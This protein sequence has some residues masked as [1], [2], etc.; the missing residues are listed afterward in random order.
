[1]T[2][3]LEQQ[4]YKCLIQKD[5]YQASSLYEQAIAEAPSKKS[6]YWYLGLAL[7]LQGQ[8]TE[9]QSTWLLA[10][11]EGEVEEVEEWNGELM[12]VLKA[13]AERCDDAT[14]W[15]IRQQMREIQP[16][17]LDNLLHLT[18]LSIKQET[19]TGE[20]LTDWGL[21][22]IVRTEPC[23]TVNPKWLLDI[24]KEVLNSAP[25][26]PATVDFTAA[27][28]PHL[29][30]LPNCLGIIIEAVLLIAFSLLQPRQALKLAELGL[31][32]DSANEEFLRHLSSL[33]Q[34]TG[35]YDQGI[36]MAEKCYALA[37]TLPNQIFAQNLV[38][39]GLMGA[40]GHW[41]KALSVSQQLESLLKLLQ[42]AQIS[43]VDRATVIRLYACGFF[44]PYLRD[45]APQNREVINQIAQWCQV[46]IEIYAREKI[47]QYRQRVKPGNTNRPLKIGYLSTCMRRHSIGWLAR[48]LFEYHDHERFQIHG[49]FVAAN[50]HQFKTNQISDPLHEWYVNHVDKANLLRLYPVEITDQIHADEI[51]ILVDLDSLTNNLCCEVMAYKPAPVQVTWLGW[52][53]SGIPTIDYYIADPY[54]LPANAQDYYTEKIWRLPHTYIAVDG[55]EAGVPTLRRDLLDIPND[56]VVYLSSQLGYKR[57]LE[58]AHW[59]M[60]ILK[61][62]PN[63]Y[64]LIK[65]FADEELIKSFF[66]QIAAEEGVS[67][68]QLRFLPE[69][70]SEALHRG[71][72]SIADIVLDTYPY[73]G[74]TTTLETLW[75]CIPLVTRV[76]EQFASRNSYTM[77]MNAGVTE[78]IA[79]TDEE[80]IE[81]GIRLGKDK[82]LRQQIAWKL[83]QS[84]KTSAL[85]NG[86]QFT[87]DM[88]Q[89]YEQMWQIYLNS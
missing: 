59:Q 49:Y 46:A 65:G 67:M 41:E 3:N 83:Q 25:L 1:M 71:N 11:M 23:L 27:C 79:W 13:E 55:F 84:R 85:W 88:E 53:A 10:M 43:E 69:V 33:Y 31:R 68:E 14:T 5:Y 72:L 18:Q 32:L 30:H 50:S 12:Q 52:D 58:T 36:A 81:W 70:P 29:Q 35:N 75:M 66:H 8:E 26:H 34:D 6:N 4:A 42:T 87:R 73:N 57:H 16:Q 77:M 60:R 17:S 19:F 38:L 24:L 80:Y 54:V 7:L 56:A 64:F 89:A 28:L 51:D 86:R 61:A 74:A 78:G 76:G 2:T 63:S 37:Q 44:F 20:E 62:V 45:L 39:R 48:W 15:I 22:E 21:I 47:G 40:T 9:A 82:A